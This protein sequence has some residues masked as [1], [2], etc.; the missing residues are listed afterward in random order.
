MGSTTPQHTAS[1]VDLRSSFKCRILKNSCSYS[2]SN[3][4]AA[5]A[6]NTSLRLSRQKSNTAIISRRSLHHHH[7]IS[8][9][10]HHHLDHDDEPLP[11]SSLLTVLYFIRQSKYESSQPFPYIRSCIHTISMSRWQSSLANM[12]ICTRGPSTISLHALSNI[13]HHHNI[14][15]PR[16]RRCA[17]KE[18]SHDK[19]YC[20]KEKDE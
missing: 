4:R 14:I 13:T 11:Y 9:H 6:R 1:S 12:C 8:P 10:N 7:H 17:W 15:K 16:E 5:G 19:C 3:L 18:N 20:Q 2:Y